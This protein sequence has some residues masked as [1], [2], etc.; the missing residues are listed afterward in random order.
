MGG[1]AAGLIGI[2]TLLLG[3]ALAATGVQSASAADAPAPGMI[4][5]FPTYTVT[6]STTPGTTFTGSVNFPAAAAFPVTT[7]TTNSTTTKAPTGESAWLGA[8]TGFGQQFGSSRSQPY[9]YLSPGPGGVST[10]TITFAGAPP[11]GWGF[12][13]GDIDADFVEL[14]ATD[15]SGPIPAA[16]LGALLN[17]QDT[18]GT[19]L[20]NYCNNSPKPSSC[21][22]PGPFTDTATWHPNG[23]TVGTTVYTNPI[24][25]GHGTDTSG[26]YDWFLPSSSIR[27]LTLTYHV[28]SGFPTYQ[29]WMAAPAPLATIT[30]DVAP[31]AGE[32]DPAGTMVALENTDGTPV[33]D[34]QDQ[35]VLIPVAADGRFSIPTAEADYE[36]AF[37]VPP[38]FE[39]IP[40][41]LVDAMTPTVVAPTV[42]LAADPPAVVAAPTAEP[43][44][45]TTGVDAGAPLMI[46]GALLAA[47]VITLAVALLH[48]RRNGHHPAG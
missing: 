48:R 16:A 15:A 19:P 31:P 12:A 42:E 13:L 17:A 2:S 37:D 27:T 5:V 25:L 47:G 33:L 44:L 6:P 36:L 35:P 3:F 1:R 24:V 45:P 9:G 7:F 21:T 39:P 46:A 43:R 10:T 32:T 41:E 38:G 40:P 29:F 14:S 4:G 8:S 28:L 23:A 20:L 26:A 18:S 30:G 34:I 22:G 11:A